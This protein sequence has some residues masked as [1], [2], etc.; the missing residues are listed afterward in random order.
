RTSP[1]DRSM[2]LLTRRPGAVL[3]GAGLVGLAAL[4]FTPAAA[5]P[6]AKDPNKQDA[7]FI[8]VDGVELKGTFYKGKKGKDSPVALLLHQYGMDRTKGDWDKL[9]KAL[10]DQG[11]AVLSFDF[12]GHGASTSVQPTTFWQ[13][14]FNSATHLTGVNRKKQ[15]ISFNSFKPSYHPYLVNDIAAARKY[16]EKKNDASEGNIGNLFVIGDR[17]GALIGMLWVTTEWLRDGIARQFGG[18]NPPPAGQDIAGCAWLSMPKAAGAKW[19]VD[20][21]IVRVP[22]V[23]EKVPMCFFYGEQDTASAGNAKH[24]FEH[25][26]KPNANSPRNSDTFAYPI[27]GTRLEG[28]GLLGK[29][30]L[31]ADEFLYRYVDKI[32][33]RRGAAAVWQQRGNIPEALVPIERVGVGGG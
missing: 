23:R 17:E 21:W 4:A 31:K 19:N 30:D 2:S 11:F 7:S 28:I 3:A 13:V 15:T 22:Q 29:Q 14:P 25:V 33:T 20:D 26:L 9:A 6:P 18:A 24:Y 12:R 10:Q 5:Q 27:K 32:L 16:L 8:T 1:E